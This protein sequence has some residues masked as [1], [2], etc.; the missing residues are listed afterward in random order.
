MNTWIKTF[1]EYFY[2]NGEIVDE[3]KMPWNL[4]NEF[5]ATA[6]HFSDFVSDFSII[7]HTDMAKVKITLRMV[8]LIRN[9]ICSEI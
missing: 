4:I 5:K 1:R 6:E 3:S 9:D 7:D 8:E 2:I